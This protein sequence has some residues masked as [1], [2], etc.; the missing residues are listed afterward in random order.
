MEEGDNV[1]GFGLLSQSVSQAL[2]LSSEE[3]RRE[4]E[5]TQG[6]TLCQFFLKLLKLLVFLLWG[7]VGGSIALVSGRAVRKSLRCFRE[8]ED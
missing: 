3:T 2:L 5:N 7:N 4:E 8:D 1:E 6:G